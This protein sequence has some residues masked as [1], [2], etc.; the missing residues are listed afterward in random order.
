MSGHP[1]YS[2]S[3]KV[4]YH[5][6]D[7]IIFLYDVCNHKSHAN[8]KSWLHEITDCISTNDN[9]LD[10]PDYLLHN[11]NAGTGETCAQR[12]IMQ[13]PRLVIGNKVDLLATALDTNTL[14]ETDRYL[15][16]VPHIYTVM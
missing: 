7:A 8:I 1:H 3:R 15:Q 14:G 2:L 9:V 13:V 5:Q 16:D 4:Y 11:L 6:I 10:L 12:A